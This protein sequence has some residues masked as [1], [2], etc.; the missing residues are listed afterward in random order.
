MGR[1]GC[2]YVG[3]VLGGG[4]VARV[5]KWSEVDV[6]EG[7]GLVLGYDVVDW[8]YL[9]V[10]SLFFDARERWLL[11]YPPTFGMILIISRDTY[12]RQL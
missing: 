7:L 3:D 1:R 2:A 9:L 6:V 5:L 4:D 11:D 12:V 10:T 8:L